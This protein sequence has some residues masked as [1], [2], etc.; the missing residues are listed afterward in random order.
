MK[1]KQTKTIEEDN[2]VK[3]QAYILT[4]SMTSAIPKITKY[5]HKH[6]TGSELLMAL[7][8]LNAFYRY[9]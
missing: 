9:S 3:V 4:C 8:F 2:C 6:D 5:G 1:T 7:Q